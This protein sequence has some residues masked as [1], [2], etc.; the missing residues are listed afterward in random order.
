M[1]QAVIFNRELF[2]KKEAVK[3]L[4]EHKITPLKAHTTKNY[5]RFRMSE[6][7]KNA[8]YITKNINDGV[9]LIIITDDVGGLSFSGIMKSIKNIYS[10]IKGVRL[11]YKPSVKK[12]LNSV[13]TLQ[14]KDIYVCRVPIHKMINKI[15]SFVVNKPHDELFHL[16]MVVKLENDKMYRIE[17]NEEIN[18]IE[19]KNIECENIKV[20]F[21]NSLTING[22]L[23]N[24]KK[25][26]GEKDFFIYSALYDNCQHFIYNILVSNNIYVSPELKYWILAP[27]KDLV[28]KW[29]ENIA[30]FM[31][32]LKARLNVATG[33]N[34]SK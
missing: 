27:V 8:R 10:A 4:K 11:D 21:A 6:P 12:I 17:K 9:S 32:S 30:F 3:W 1:I 24:T 13:G 16:F 33:G 5:Y 25:S 22:M 28:P 34:Q 2:T 14:I 18:I 7:I 15:L 20:D 29:A 19:F 26:L 31:T 23:E